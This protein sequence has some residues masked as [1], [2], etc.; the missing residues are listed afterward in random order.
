VASAEDEPAAAG[1]SAPR[2]GG[3]VSPHES[4][5]CIVL[6]AVTG[7]AL[8]LRLT[9]PTQFATPFG[10]WALYVV[11]LQGLFGAL[12]EVTEGFVWQ[13]RRSYLRGLALL[14]VAWILYV[15]AGLSP[16]E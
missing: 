2:P 15:V 13:R 5:L 12:W 4:L 7:T 1:W 10:R 9:L 8:A 11:S 14:A 6:I 3:R 16:T